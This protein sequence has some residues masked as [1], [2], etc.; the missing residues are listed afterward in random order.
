MESNTYEVG[1]H[2]EDLSDLGTHFPVVGKCDVAA[3]CDNICLACVM[4][5]CWRGDQSHAVIRRYGPADKERASV[6]I[7]QICN[8]LIIASND[9]AYW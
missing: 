7:E 1:V 5:D 8:A 2:S 3:R 4:S 9:R 6:F